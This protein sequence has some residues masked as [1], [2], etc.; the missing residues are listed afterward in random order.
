MF[1]QLMQNSVNRD[2][3]GLLVVSNLPVR[4][5]KIWINL[6]PHMTEDEKT[7]LKSLLEEEV[8]YEVQ[9]TEGVMNNFI[10]ELEKKTD[11]A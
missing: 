7:Q 3:V 4:E 2:I 1:Q 8:Q 5:K 6:L 11:S 9:V 10:A